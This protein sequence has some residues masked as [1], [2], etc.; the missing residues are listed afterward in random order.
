M[1]A[2]QLCPKACRQDVKRWED[3]IWVFAQKRQL[4]AIIPYLPTD[5]PRLGHL[6][7]EMVLGHL[8]A[9]DRPVKSFLI[10]GCELI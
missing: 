2:A 7:Y 4:Q 6:V 3:W 10:P 1:K 5:N 8:L 9:N